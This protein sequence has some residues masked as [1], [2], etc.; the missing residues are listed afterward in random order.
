MQDARPGPKLGWYLLMALVVYAIVVSV[1]WRGA[2]ADLREARLLL[3][4]GAEP[5]AAVAIEGFAAV[6]APDPAAAASTARGAAPAGGALAA[7]LESDVGLW[8]PIPGARMPADDA[9]LPGAPRAYRA[10]ASE[11]FVFW[12]DGAG[13]P[14]AHGT[15]VIAS[16]S[17]EV[18]RVDEPYAE[19]DETT[20]ESLIVSVADGADERELDAL[21]GRQVWIRLDDGRVLRY[22]HLSGVRPGLTVGQRVARGRVIGYVGNSGTLDGVVGRISNVRL[23]FEIRDG[24]GFAGQGLDPDGVR[25]LAASL[26]TGP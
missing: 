11:G 18:V 13:V 7:E 3:A 14:V 19:L 9:H 24:D 26:F 25:L 1:S 20:W 2:V 10:G 4:G 15:P 17:G 8:L 6:A 12:P 5:P 22:G 16:A 21:R 23:H